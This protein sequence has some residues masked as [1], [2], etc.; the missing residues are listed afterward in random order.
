MPFL[1]TSLLFLISTIGWSADLNEAY[2]SALEKNELLPIQESL[3]QQSDERISQVSGLLLPQIN[4]LTNYSRQDVPPPDPSA[5]GATS[6]F[7]QADQWN[8]RLNLVQPLFRGF[9]EWAEYR[10]RKAAKRAEE[11]ARDQ[12]RIDLFASV[13][14][15]F[16]NVLIAESQLENLRTLADLSRKRVV[17]IGDRT[18]IGRARKG[19]LLSA[20][21]QVASVQAQIDAAEQARRQARENFGF[22]SGLPVDSA[23]ADTSQPPRTPPPID[24]LLKRAEKQP[25]IVAEQNRLTA[26]DESVSVARAGHYPSLDFAA[27]YYFKRTGVLEQV[28]WDVGGVLVVPLFSG[29]VT[30]SRVEEA[31]GK[32][33]EQELRFERLRRETATKVRTAHEALQGEMMQVESLAEASE[34]SE[35]NYREQ[36]RDYKY[37]LVTNLEVL[38]AMNSFQETKQ[39]YDRMR[40]QAKISE[41]RLYAAVGEMPPER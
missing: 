41:A 11:A 39:L 17:E 19:D 3:V 5:A 37:G 23:L 20:R 24:E 15:S 30:Q 18:R 38:Q 6:R 28:K 13:S 31:V 21:A 25:L 9:G 33:K 10:G 2:R 1:V 22:V 4:F 12:A 8:S 14:E 16:Y 36:N 26:F 7:F 29:G 32:R 34:L 40:L 27:N 35:A